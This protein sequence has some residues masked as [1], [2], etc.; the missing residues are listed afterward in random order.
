MTFLLLSIESVDKNFGEGSGD[1]LELYAFSK[2]IPFKGKCVT[3]KSVEE[4]LDKYLL[5]MNHEVGKAKAKWFKQA[6]GFT[7]KN[8]KGLADQIKFDPKK[9]VQTAVTEHGVKYN[10]LINITGANKKI[11]EVKVS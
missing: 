11:I 2:L 5:N 10:Q 8:S 9:A 4:K 6:L 1:L 7:K 3:R